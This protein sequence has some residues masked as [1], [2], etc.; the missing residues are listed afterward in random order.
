MKTLVIVA[1]MD[2]EALSCGALIMSR[3]S[4][5]HDV[6]VL[7]LHTRVYNYGAWD[8]GLR[9][10]D[11]FKKSLAVLGRGG[12]LH[13]RCELMPEGEPGKVG[14]YPLLKV[15]EAALDDFKPDE[16]VIPSKLDLNQDHQHL[17]HVCDIALRPANLGSVRRILR[18]H[19]FDSV[20]NTFQYYVPFDSDRL[21]VKLEAVGCYKNEA[22]DGVHPRSPN[23][24]EA[25]HRVLGSKCGAE[26]AEGYSVV[27]YRE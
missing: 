4:N 5:G 22:R 18:S 17:A 2:D 1:H 6:Y 20:V 12:K 9:E 19:A 14:F 10:Y 11:D 27:L 3:V 7:A 8:G 16:V 26:F 24:I 13:G 21:R 23:N 15:I 25:W